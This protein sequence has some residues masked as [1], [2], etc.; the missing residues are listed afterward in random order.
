MGS[1]QNLVQMKMYKEALRDGSI[2]QILMQ[3][4]EPDLDPGI[5]M[6]RQAWW[7]AL[8]VLTLE[9][10]TVGCLDFLGYQ[11]SLSNEPQFPA[12]GTLL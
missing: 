6:K 11:S 1:N 5:Q 10:Q 8:A 9:K 12:R 3:A 2:S 7:L 4:S